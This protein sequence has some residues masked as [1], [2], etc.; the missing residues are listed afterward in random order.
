MPQ[1]NE[2]SEK[3][4]IIKFSADLL[5]GSIESLLITVFTLVCKLFLKEYKDILPEISEVWI[6]FLITVVVLFC[7][8]FL[9]EYHVLEIK[10]LNYGCML[11]LYTGFFLALVQ[12]LEILVLLNQKNS[13]TIFLKCVKNEALLF[14]AVWDIGVLYVFFHKKYLESNKKDYVEDTEAIIKEVVAGETDGFVQKVEA[15]SNNVAE[16]LKKRD[17]DTAVTS[18]IIPFSY[19]TSNKTI[20]T[21]LIANASYPEYTWMFPG[22]HVVFSEGQ[23]PETIAKARAKDEANLDVEIMDIC[24]AWSNVSLNQDPV[25]N[26]TVFKSAHFLYLFKLDKNA[27][28]YE[29]KGHEYHMDEVY[30]AEVCKAEPVTGNQKRVSVILNQDL[31]D[32]DMIKVACYSAVQKYYKTHNIESTKQKNVPAY[33]ETMLYNGFITY[34]KLK[35]I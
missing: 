32:I 7:L 12:F 19:N 22:G 15:Y 4:T 5:T 26:M 30:I 6:C 34:K 24:D 21:Y 13:E 1:T 25:D 23:S 8:Y 2:A 31:S 11:F 20:K 28:C 33:V 35:G 29:E 18:T 27:K 14:F 10:Y 3:N 16:V 9:M 17:F